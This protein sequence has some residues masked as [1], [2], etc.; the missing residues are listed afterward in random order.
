MDNTKFDVDLKYNLRDEL[1]TFVL[2]DDS[3]LL[4]TISP[5]L[6]IFDMYSDF[7]GEPIGVTEYFIPHPYGRNLPFGILYGVPKLKWGGFEKYINELLINHEGKQYG[8][9]LLKG[10]T[11]DIGKKGNKYPIHELIPIYLISVINFTDS[12]RN[13]LNFV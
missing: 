2:V 8:P 12:I 11:K 13:Q 1:N 6:D 4:Q 7:S 3:L 5:S 10:K 9:F